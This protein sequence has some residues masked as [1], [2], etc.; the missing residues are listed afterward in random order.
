MIQT[1]T[2]QMCFKLFLTSLI[3][4]LLSFNSSRVTLLKESGDFMSFSATTKN[5]LSRI[6][7]EKK[8]CQ[9]AEVAGFIRMCGTIQ[10]SGQRKLSLKLITENPAAARK[11]IKLLK[12]YFDIHI[13]LVISQSKM[14]KKHHYYELI[15]TH[16]M[17]ADNILRKIGILVERDGWYDIDYSIPEKIIKKRCC[18]R[19]YL[20]G[21]F[22]GSGSVTD[23]G[24]AYHLEIVTNNSMLSEDIKSLLNYFNLNAKIVT[25]KK[26]FVIYL[27]EGEQIVDFLNIIGAYNTLMDLENIRIVKEMRNKVNRLVNCETANLNKIVDTS[28]RQMSN[29]QYIEET[30]GLKILPSKLREIAELR[31]EHSE[32]S[33]QE[34]GEML[35]PPVGKS[36]VN[37][38]MK[39][40]EEIAE[41]IRKNEL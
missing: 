9:L 11:I 35:N 36:G 2:N 17:K 3:I 14:L 34:L 15:I 33:L 21:A 31:L 8:C 10:L 18:K 38:R 7:P 1:F 41:K 13:D 16:D 4:S 40:I 29:I 6:I 23:P 22:L 12:M 5:E 25:R 39:K 37:H 27:K 26:N 28:V 20:R 24:K 30:R 32:A 19:A